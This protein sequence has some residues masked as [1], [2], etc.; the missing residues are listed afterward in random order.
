MA[1]K[2]RKRIHDW[3]GESEKWA[4]EAGDDLV[5]AEVVLEIARARLA[6]KPSREARHAVEDAEQNLAFAKV[7]AHHMELARQAIERAAIARRRQ[8]G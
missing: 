5:A 6:V 4:A 1:A 3:I 7:A 2:R 8:G